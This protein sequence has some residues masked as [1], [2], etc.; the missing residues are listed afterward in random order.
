M[1]INLARNCGQALQAAPVREAYLDVG[2]GDVVLVRFR[3]QPGVAAGPSLSAVPGGRALVRTGP[4]Y[5]PRLRSHGG[6]SATIEAQGSC[7]TV[8]LWPMEES[9]ESR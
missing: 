9:Q 2:G 5:L 7:F 6:G 3:D 8:E 4:V 1:F